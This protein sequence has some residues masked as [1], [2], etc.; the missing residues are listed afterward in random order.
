MTARRPTRPPIAHTPARVTH[1]IAQYGDTVPVVVVAVIGQVDWAAY[2]VDLARL[3]QAVP[4]AQGDSPEDVLNKCF[5]YA[6]QYG[7][8]L[9]TTA[10]NAL[11]PGLRFNEEV[12]GSRFYRE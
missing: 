1:A 5:N 10:A 11:F 3:L 8:K 12:E 6:A 4:F 2:R 9:S 7:D